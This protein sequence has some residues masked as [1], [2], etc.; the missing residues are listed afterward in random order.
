[1]SR[2]ERFVGGISLAY[3]NQALTALV[4]LLLTPFLLFRIGQH[5]YGL[6]L[7]GTQIM[8][9]LGLLD[10][11]VVALLP[12]ETALAT[13]RAKNIGEASDLPLIIGQTVRM[14]ILQMP[15]VALA[16]IVAWLLTPVEWQGL[17]NPIGVILLAFVLTFP[18]RIFGAV[19]QGLQDFSFLG[20]TNIV[21]YL[22][23]TALTVGLVLAGFGFYSLATCC[24][25]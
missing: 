3:T 18:L 1:M 9:Y 13:G 16:A 12:R 20:K 11:G 6:W 22:A 24:D 10:L 21:A 7:V 5:D 17:R 23:S 8:F 15:L 4:G 19:L 2:T 25:L 14:V